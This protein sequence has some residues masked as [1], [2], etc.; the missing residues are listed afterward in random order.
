M[1][2]SVA[3]PQLTALP[4]I[5]VRRGDNTT[6]PSPPT[7]NNNQLILS[8]TQKNY[9]QVYCI[10]KCLLDLDPIKLYAYQLIF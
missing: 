3:P 6:T 9:N 1:F 2:V 10:K 5:R 7:A 4:S 8:R